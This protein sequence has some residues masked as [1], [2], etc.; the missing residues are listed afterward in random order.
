MQLKLINT[1]F[2]L[3]CS[4]YLSSVGKFEK[5]VEDPIWYS[6]AKSALKI[7]FVCLQHVIRILGTPPEQ[8]L[9]INI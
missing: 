5:Y 1:I 3:D 6:G 4:L 2:T 9:D 7:D 8:E